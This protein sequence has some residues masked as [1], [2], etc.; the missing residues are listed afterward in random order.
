MVFLRL[1]ILKTPTYFY[2]VFL[3]EQIE[4]GNTMQHDRFNKEFDKFDRDAKRIFRTAATLSVFWFLVGIAI[5]SG[6][7]YT[8][9]RV[10]AHYGIW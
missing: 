4:K 9:Y 5:L 3:S 7:V 6:V 1:A 2:Q 8:I 10:L